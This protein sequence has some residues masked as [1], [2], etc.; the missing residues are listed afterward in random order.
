[1]MMAFNLIFLMIKLYN[2]FEII[3]SAGIGVKFFIFFLFLL[4]SCP[5]VYLFFHLFYLKQKG[6][7]KIK[8]ML[9]K[10]LFILLFASLSNKNDLRL[11]KIL[12]QICSVK[13]FLINHNFCSKCIVKKPLQVYKSF[14]ESFMGISV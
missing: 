10:K 9:A 13:M 3:N 6:F 7:H 12:L 8:K 2:Y 4:K 11:P 5:K 1:M 14:L